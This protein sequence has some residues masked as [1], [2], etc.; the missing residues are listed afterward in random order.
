MLDLTK[1]PYI[2][3]AP[4]TYR[5]ADGREVLQIVIHTSEAPKRP[6]SARSVAEYFHNGSEGRFASAHYCVDSEDIYHCVQNKDI[7]YGAPGANTIGIHIEH[8]GYSAESADDWKDAYNTQML[9]MSAELTATL[10]VLFDIPARWLSPS[11]VAGHER[12]ITGHNNVTLA[13]P[14]LH[15]THMDPGPSFPI[16]NYVLLVQAN[17]QAKAQVTDPA[18][19]IF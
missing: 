3:A 5:S 12:G 7:A 10:C 2:Q 18:A 6:G 17:L 16:D 13:Y 14:H 8:A 1:L 15:G 11:E 4:N 19:R 9:P